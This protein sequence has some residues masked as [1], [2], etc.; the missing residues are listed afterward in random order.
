MKKIV[1]KKIQLLI[2]LVCICFLPALFTGGCNHLKDTAPVGPEDPN[3]AEDPNHPEDPVDP[4][5]LAVAFYAYPYNICADGV[6]YTTISFG[7]TIDSTPIPGILIKF[8]TTQG[9][10]FELCN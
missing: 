2:I 5:G 7:V 1:P 6:S 4:E 9:N 3:Q 10:F 8:E